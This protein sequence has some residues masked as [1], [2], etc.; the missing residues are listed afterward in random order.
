M[1]LTLAFL[2]SPQFCP[3]TAGPFA[4]LRCWDY[5]DRHVTTVRMEDAVSDPRGFVNQFFPMSGL[6]GKLPP[7]FEHFQF[8]NFTGRKVGE[9]DN[10]SHYRSGD[11]DGWRREL[12]SVVIDYVRQEFRPLLEKFYPEALTDSVPA[13]RECELQAGCV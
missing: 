10:K 7:D 11:P 6:T 9:V 13:D 1:L 8:E 4:G 5:D 3:H 12:P 2:F